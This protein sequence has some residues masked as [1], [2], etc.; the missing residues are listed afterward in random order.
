MKKTLYLLAAVLIP[1]L[2]LGTAG[3]ASAPEETPAVPPAEETAETVPPATE[4]NE[5]ADA[6]LDALKAEAEALRERCLRAGADEA[7]PEEWN[8]A[9]EAFRRGSENY[10]K[11]YAQSQEGFTQAIAQY[12][13]IEG[14]AA[15]LFAGQLQAEIEAAR[16]AAIE[17]GA[18]EYYPEQFGMAEAAAE[19]ALEA[20]NRGDMETAYAEGQK[21][22]AWY[23]MLK[24][25]I[26]IR[27]LRQKILENG[28]DTEDPEAFAAAEAKYNDAV[29]QFTA[30]AE[31]AR[32]VSREALAAYEELCASGFRRLA[33]KEKTRAG[34]MRDL[35]NSIKAQRSMAEDYAAAEEVYG[36]AEAL[37]AENDW[38]SAFRTYEESSILFAEVYQNALYKRN[39]AEAAM[40][41]ARERQEAST[42]LALEADEIA[43]LP[44]E[45]E[46]GDTAEAA[47]EPDSAGQTE[48]VAGEE[49]LVEDVPAESAA[50][51][52]GTE[53]GE[54]YAV[55]VPENTN[56]DSPENSEAA[57]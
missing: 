28:F 53:T 5:P 23:Q 32:A 35:C 20:Y 19:Q 39:A 31:N 22:L 30:D 3:C 37:G 51:A 55:P 29:M 44:D 52:S 38:E 46:T 9:E 12:K 50:Q 48:T 21:V 13:A 45:E 27:D 1:V 57:E 6:A 26:D 10:G 14:Q 47:A 4:Q 36:A 42:A 54:E 24:T 17:A 7:L 8:A 43:P 2:A 33:E 11:V 18:R 34:E 15:A 49:I 41:A 56:G 40:N 25:G 16:E